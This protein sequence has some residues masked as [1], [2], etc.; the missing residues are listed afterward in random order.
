MQRLLDRQIEDFVDV[1]AVI[2]NLEDLG[3]VARAFAL[4]ADQLDIGEKLHFDGDRA[5]ALADLAS[6]ARNVEREMAGGVAALLALGQ[7]CEKFANGVESLDVGDG[8]RAR[9]ATDRR[10]IDQHNL[11]D[12]LGAVDGSTSACGPPVTWPFS[13]A[14]AL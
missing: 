12:P 9:R 13:A 8:I 4:L 14:S 3:L 5:V 6:A 11:V 10:L 1:L 2:A 7:R